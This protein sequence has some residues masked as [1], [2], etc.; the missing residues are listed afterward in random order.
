[1]DRS[2]RMTVIMGV[3]T[4]VAILVQYR[5]LSQYSRYEEMMT[6]LGVIFSARIITLIA[7][8]FMLTIPFS[9]ESGIVKTIG[10]EKRI[11]LSKMQEYAKKIMLFFASCGLFC[12]V[13]RGLGF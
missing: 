6:T 4:I 3:I 12:L 8:L 10:K 11:M 5:M 2:L 1:M 7:F 9:I 13:L